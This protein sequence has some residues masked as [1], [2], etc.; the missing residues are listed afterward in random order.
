MSSWNIEKHAQYTKLQADYT[1]FYSNE[2][3]FYVDNLSKFL[4]IPNLSISDTL[5]ILEKAT[6]IRAILKD[7]DRTVSP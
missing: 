4:N 1:E 6:E 5:S 7:W 3:P 2:L